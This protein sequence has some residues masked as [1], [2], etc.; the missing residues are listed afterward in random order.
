MP[1]VPATAARCAIQPVTKLGSMAREVSSGSLP[2]IGVPSGCRPLPASG[3]HHEALPVTV[4]SVACCGPYLATEKPQ[5]RVRSVGVQPMV[6][7]VISGSPA[8][9]RV[10]PTNRSDDEPY[11]RFCGLGL[12][13]GRL[14]LVVSS[15]QE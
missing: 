10:A 6:G 5:R 15:C 13:S 12:S 2:V 7:T 14:W 11:G 8:A 9:T 4:H 3:L 1:A